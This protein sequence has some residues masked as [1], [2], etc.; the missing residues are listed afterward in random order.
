MR[1]AK[2]DKQPVSG[3]LSFLKEN[4]LLVL[5]IVIAISFCM[6]GITGVYG[7]SA[8]PDEFGYWA[9]AAAL[10]G[11]DWSEISSLGSYYSYGYSVLLI[12]ILA[13]FKGSISAYRAAVIVNLLL[14]C[15]SILILYN[16][17][18]RIAQTEKNNTR[19]I[20]AIISA[21]YPA[22]V[23][24]TQTTMAESL[25]YFLFVLTSLLIIRFF[26]KPGIV[27]GLVFVAVLV[28]CYFVHMRCIGLI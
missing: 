20:I 2:L 17:L 6:Y 19:A 7:F 3:C 25:L 16:I 10:L 21:L 18:I 12:G 27:R 1:K 15:A 23:F 26:E 28:Y 4:I 13:L 9:P 24:Y 11:Y 22:W 5:G 14:Q 8:F